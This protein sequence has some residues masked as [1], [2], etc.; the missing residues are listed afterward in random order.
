MDSYQLNETSM[1]FRFLIINSI[2][3]S[4]ISCTD[5]TDVDFRKYEILTLA[6]EIN[7]Q[8]N[9][10]LDTS[11]NSEECRI[12]K[13]I[14]GSYELKYSYDLTETEKFSPLFYSIKV[15]RL[16]SEKDA[17]HR[18]IGRITWKT[19]LYIKGHKV[20]IRN[21]RTPIPES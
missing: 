3:T 11:G 17:I 12:R 1:V 4:F 6:S 18:E 8:F 19:D 5:E 20:S 9:I 10:P 16:Q 7:N 14:D 21:P 2:L 15:E 13:F